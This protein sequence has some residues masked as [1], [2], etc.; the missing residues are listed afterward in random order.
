[1]TYVL[2]PLAY[3]EDALEPYMSAT[4]V[5]IHRELHR[6]YVEQANAAN[7][8]AQMQADLHALFWRSLRPPM[9]WPTQFTTY[10]GQVVDA[11]TYA[12]VMQAIVEATTAFQGPGWVVLTLAAAG[13]IETEPFVLTGRPVGIP[14]LAV[15][16]WEHA[17][18][19]DHGI[20]RD[21]YFAALAHVI[22]WDL[23]EQILLSL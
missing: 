21:D 4:T 5:K 7:V 6:R 1:M 11:E 10:F 18:L 12:E 14:L 9:P 13:N 8:F 2:P 17:Y 16:V 20:S 19:L 22:N 3:R 15:D 23:P